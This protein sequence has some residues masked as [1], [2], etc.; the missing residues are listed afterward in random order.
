[1]IY[2]INEI[3]DKSNNENETLDSKYAARNKYDRLA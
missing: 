2:Q 3:L 1:M